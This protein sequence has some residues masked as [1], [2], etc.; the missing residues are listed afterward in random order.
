MNDTQRHFLQIAKHALNYYDLGEVHI[1]DSKVV[2]HIGF[3]V[4]PVWFEKALDGVYRLFMPH[5]EPQEWTL[6]VVRFDMACL[7]EINH[8]DL[9][10][11]ETI[12]LS[13][14]ITREDQRYG[15]RKF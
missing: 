11:I 9:V 8:V 2:G 5:L 12:P 7:A 3:T 4:L 15:P 13:G 14:S 10:S 1:D 6:I